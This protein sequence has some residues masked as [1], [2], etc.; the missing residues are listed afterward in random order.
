MTPL[1]RCSHIVRLVARNNICFNRHSGPRL[2]SM[3]RGHPKIIAAQL[4]EPTVI[5]VSTGNSAA[6]RAAPALAMMMACLAVLDGCAS[7][8]AR[9]G[10]SETQPGA[11]A[12][13]E[14]ECASAVVVG[15]RWERPTG[16][17]PVSHYDIARNG[18]PMGSATDASFADTTVAESARY[19]YSVTAVLSSGAVIAA[20]AV[21]VDTPTASP[22]GD[23]PYCNSSHIGSMSWDWA[24]GHTEPNGSDLWP[25]TWGKDGKTYTFF[26]DGGGFGGD[27][28]RGRASFGV[29]SIAGRPPL[30]AA[31]L[32][33]VYGGFNSLHPSTLAGKASSIIAV[34]S[35]FYTLGGLFD[36]GES[37]GAPRSGAPLR[38][39]LAFSRHNAHSW[40]AASWTFCGAGPQASAGAFCPTGFINHGPGNAGAPQDHVYLLGFAD[41]SAYWRESAETDSIANTYLARVPNRRV[42]DP[43]AYRYFAGL[44]PQGRPIWSADQTKM[45]PVFTDRNPI[46]PGCGGLCNMTALLQDA[47]FDAGIQR[48]IAT[49]QGAYVGQTSFY[50]APHPWGPW[51]TISYNNIAAGTGTGGWADLGIAGGA[52]LGVHVVNA[53]TS[54][55]GL[56][57]WLTYSSDGKA[58]PGALF[59]P[60]GTAMDSFNLVRAQLIPGAKLG[61]QA[62]PARD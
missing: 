8:R 11:L 52:S 48:Y 41:S 59:P 34:G 3:R 15:L 49:A 16:I 22:N 24:G 58:P 31:V 25:V 12:G 45:R 42:L 4:T 44:N 50:D 1:A 27:N 17:R 47:V 60:E 19:T 2:E 57:L 13:L 56:T 21:D 38:I 33:N 51:T 54:P 5:R 7:L 39:Q 23:A 18:A 26:G 43:K 46:R 9:A 6:A 32:R 62:Q 36:P 61:T 40:R 35:D 55:D 29:A 10:G 28:R 37:N 14:I 53:W 20:G 30:S